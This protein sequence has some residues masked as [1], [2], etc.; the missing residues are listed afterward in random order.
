M[1]FR[2]TTF[3]LKN[4]STEST[5]FQE[6]PWMAPL[7]SQQIL[8]FKRKQMNISV[9]LLY[10]SLGNRSNRALLRFFL[11]VGIVNST[12]WRKCS[13]SIFATQW[14]LSITQW[15]TKLSVI[16]PLEKARQ[17][18]SRSFIGR[19]PSMTPNILFTK[20]CFF[21]LN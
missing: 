18:N 5:R 15:T 1:S 16:S 11:T 12:N 14:C 2:V 8:I 3:S 4:L 17:L 10:N 13:Y 19:A 7:E 9:L 21:S 20:E 6:L